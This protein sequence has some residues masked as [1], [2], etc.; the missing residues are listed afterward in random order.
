MC[1]QIVSL[2]LNCL[3]VVICNFRKQ[4]KSM[5]A[6]MNQRCLWCLETVPNVTFNKKAHTIPKSLGGQNFNQNVCDSCN[7][8]FGFRV[9]HYSIEEVLKE[10]FI[11]SR[12]RLLVRTP[13]RKIGNFKSRFFEI[14]E[15]N[16]RRRLVIK[17]AFRFDDN[18]Q[19]ELCRYFKRGLYKMYFE[20]L[21]RQINLGFE[22]KYKLIRNFARYDKGDLPVIYFSR[23]FGALFALMSEAETPVLLFD[24]MKYLYTDEH[25]TEIEFLGHVFGFQITDCNQVDLE[26]YIHASLKLKQNLFKECRIIERLTD[27]DFSL[28]I[29]DE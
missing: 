2:C 5:I 8:F 10:T 11:I 19:K 14:K 17:T 26:D 18:S 6:N 21:N 3:A 27:V 7:E 29:L 13:K 25:F 28:S 22:D 20:E 15:R 12:Q 23:A 16:G 9:K 24:R 4:S 1:K